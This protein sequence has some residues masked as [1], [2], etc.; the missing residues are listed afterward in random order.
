M[1]RLLIPEAWRPM[2]SAFYKR[3][4][5]SRP[6]LLSKKGAYGCFLPEGLRPS[7]NILECFKPEGLRPAANILE[8]FSYRRACAQPLTF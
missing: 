2:P 4:G 3:Y 5:A 6:V 8:C 1:V 7:A